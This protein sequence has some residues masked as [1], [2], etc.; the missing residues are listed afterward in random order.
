MKI[1]NIRLDDDGV[2]AVDAVRAAGYNVSFVMREL[3]K[4]FAEEKGL[5]KRSK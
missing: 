4:H 1:T 3:I 2:R 5:L